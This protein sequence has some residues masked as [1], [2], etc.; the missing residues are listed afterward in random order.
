MSVNTQES[1][2][3]IS[4]AV[5]VIVR[6]A[7]A[8]ADVASQIDQTFVDI[9]SLL[10]AC[11]GK[12]IVAG[13]GTSGFIARRGAHIFAVSGTPSLFL[14][15]TEGQHGSV[16]AL[17]SND[18][19]IV[20]SKGGSSDEVNKLASLAKQEGLVVVAMTSNGSSALAD[21]ADHTVVLKRDD[22]A[23]PGGLIALGST[24]A[25]A[26][27]LDSMSVVLMR[28]KAYTWDQVFFT[29]PGGAVG[30]LRQLPE[31]LPSLAIPQ[32]TKD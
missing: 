9:A 6:E 1:A 24:L 10:M 30:Q 29:H 2:A 4:A 8:V 19:L 7:K 21:I 31:E 5:E 12:V 25:Y 16:G 22:I 11:E 17:R 3:V 14:H 26:A 18:I 15:P 23:D 13:V 20:L 28:A 27:W 32:Y